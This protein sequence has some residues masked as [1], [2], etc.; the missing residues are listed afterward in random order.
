MLNTKSAHSRQSL[1][2][3]PWT[4]FSLFIAISW[5]LSLAFTAQLPTSDLTPPSAAKSKQLDPVL[6]LSLLSG[7][8]LIEH[9]SRSMSALRGSE[10]L[11]RISS[12]GR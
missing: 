10:F 7:L 9:N 3:I 1:P 5:M 2:G 12:F 11:G 4:G 6:E 8:H